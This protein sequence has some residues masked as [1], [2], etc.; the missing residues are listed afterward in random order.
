MAVCEAVAILAG[1]SR[2]ARRAFVREEG[3]V[4]AFQSMARG[5]VPPVAAAA[6]AAAASLGAR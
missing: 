5:A 2:A 6:A 1:A 4:A 3:V